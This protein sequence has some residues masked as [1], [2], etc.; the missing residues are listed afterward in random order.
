MIT[1]QPLHWHD[2]EAL[3]YCRHYCPRF[4]TDADFLLLVD[5]F[6]HRSPCFRLVSSISIYLSPNLIVLARSWLASWASQFSAGGEDL[7]LYP[8]L[9]LLYFVKRFTPVVRFISEAFFGM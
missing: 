2:K 9:S 5:Q 4:S 6:S 1:V 3:A 8:C 7:L